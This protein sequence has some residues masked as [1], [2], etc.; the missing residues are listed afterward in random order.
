MRCISGLPIRVARTSEQTPMYATNN[1]GYYLDMIGI[2]SLAKFKLRFGDK[3]DEGLVTRAKV[4]T[5]AS[6]A[7]IMGP[8]AA[9]LGRSA[10]REIQK[11]HPCVDVHAIN[12]SIA[13][14]KGLSYEDF[15]KKDWYQYRSS[16]YQQG[17]AS[18]SWQ[19]Y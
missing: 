6:K 9:L 7:T 10:D 18:S 16:N 2:R 1:A 14:E 15:V 3:F 11:H 5:F 13:N 12:F 4:Q 19:R 17:G 8:F